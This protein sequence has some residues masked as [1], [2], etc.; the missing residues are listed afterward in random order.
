MEQTTKLLESLVFED[1][2][3]KEHSVKLKENFTELM[4]EKGSRRIEI[5]NGD[6]APYDN[7]IRAFVS[8]EEFQQIYFGLSSNLTKR[9]LYKCNVDKDTFISNCIDEINTYLQY[10]TVKKTINIETGKAGFNDSQM[11]KM[12]KSGDKTFD[13]D[14]G[15]VVVPKSDF[16][17]VNYIMHHTMLPRLA[18][19][20]ILNGIEKREAL[21]FQDIL[22]RVT[23]KILVKLNDA[24]ASNISSYEVI[25]GYELDEGQIFATDTIN[26][27]DFN[28]EWRVFK[29][30]PNRKKALNEYYKMDSKGEKKF[31]EKLEAND[32]VILFTKLKKGGFVIDTPYGNYSPDWAI[33]CRKEGLEAGTVG[34]YF[35]VETKAEKL[36]KDLTKVELNKI[37]CGK[38]HFKAVSELVNFDWVNS[39]EDF[40]TKFG[41]KESI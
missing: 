2:I 39:Y 9:T 37:H 36:E 12:E 22:D 6:N 19:F 3:L 1:E 17:I 26:E 30:N 41:V 32:N 27:E 31:A 25:D 24:K 23:Q 15:M 35:I 20:K 33:V 7:S 8:E 14:V 28:D 34:I 10:F 4:V 21:N 11:F 13:M 40:K 38:L 18:I 16:E 5:N 29:S